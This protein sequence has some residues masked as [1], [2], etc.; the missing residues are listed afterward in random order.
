LENWPV[1]GNSDRWI[2]AF[3]CL[4][5]VI[6]QFTAQP[7]TPTFEPNPAPFEVARLRLSQPAASARD[8]AF[9]FDA[10]F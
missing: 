5:F 7:Q 6:S 1:T 2:T 3:T 10:V 8:C 9:A 4:P